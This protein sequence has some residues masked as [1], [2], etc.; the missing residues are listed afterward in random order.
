MI[1]A[2]TG[3]IDDAGFVYGGYALT[4]AAVGLFTWRVVS[5][6]RKLGKQLPDDEKYWT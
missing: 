4:F 6:G 1:A 5:S 3:F 2:L